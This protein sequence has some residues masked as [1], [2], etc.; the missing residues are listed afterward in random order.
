MPLVARYFIVLLGKYGVVISQVGQKRTKKQEKE[1]AKKM[2][3]KEGNNVSFC[4][5]LVMRA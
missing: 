5:I 4:L 1:K 2:K 3:E